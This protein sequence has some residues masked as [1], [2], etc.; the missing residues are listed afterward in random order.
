[1]TDYDW[2]LFEREVKSNILYA[3][4]ILDEVFGSENSEKTETDEKERLIAFQELLKVLF[5]NSLSQS[6]VDESTEKQ[7]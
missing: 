1:M 3:L 4:D 6:V 7:Q 5:A 2:E